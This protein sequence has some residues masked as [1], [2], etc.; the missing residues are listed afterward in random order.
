MLKDS[1]EIDSRNLGSLHNYFARAWAWEL[2]RFDPDE[3]FTVPN[4]VFGSI[5]VSSPILP[6][7]FDIFAAFVQG[8]SRRGSGPHV[9]VGAGMHPGLVLGGSRASEGAGPVPPL[10][11]KVM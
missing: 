3:V 2:P 7:R 10:F 11:R 5:T 1:L 6:G 4:I 9:R 8:D